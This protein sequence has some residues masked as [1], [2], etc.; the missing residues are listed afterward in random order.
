MATNKKQTNVNLVK[1]FDSWE[2]SW[3]SSLNK[4]MPWFDKDGTA[5]KALLTTSDRTTYY[6]SGSIIFGDM[7][8]DPAYWMNKG[9]NWPGTI[10][11]WVNEDDCDADKLPGE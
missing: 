8:Y 10:W 3:W 7:E 4:R 5:H 6:P 1:K 9:K 11:Y 2:Y